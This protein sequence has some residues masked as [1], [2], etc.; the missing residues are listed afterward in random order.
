MIRE[1]N[2]IIMAVEEAFP[3]R[4]AAGTP[5]RLVSRAHA[6]LS[7]DTSSCCSHRPLLPQ[8]DPRVRPLLSLERELFSAWSRD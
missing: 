3:D 7:F 5:T 6:R 2:D 4:N 1:S 8:G